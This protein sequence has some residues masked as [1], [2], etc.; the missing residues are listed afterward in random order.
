[1]YEPMTKALISDDD[2]TLAGEA[3]LGL[4][5]RA[6]EAVVT[7]RVATDTNFA[8]EHAVWNE[9][10]VPLLGA[11]PVPPPAHIWNNIQAKISVAPTRR[12]ANAPVRLW[13]AIAGTATAVAAT[14]AV[15]LVNPPAQA[16]LPASQTLVAALGSETGRAAMTA[17]YD[18]RRGELVVT[19][20]AMNADGRFPELWL[21]DAS[22]DAK[23]LGFVK[24]DSPT[25]VPVGQAMRAR[26]QS[27]MTL[28][29]TL[30]PNGSA[31]HA[32]ASGPVIVSGK[33]EIL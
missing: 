10:L 11:A 18:T 25:R 31:P 4:L 29:V 27:G 19:P 30:E 26:M 20:V 17:A 2:I 32:K 21:I 5:D 28:A 9:R 22:G 15:M 8:R 12:A 16:P 14:L 1:V 33:I 6:G 23:S 3:A 7:A 13:Q 24:A